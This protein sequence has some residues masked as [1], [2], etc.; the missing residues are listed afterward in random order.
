MFILEYIDPYIMTVHWNLWGSKYSCRY[1]LVL[2]RGV[3]PF[4]SYFSTCQITVTSRPI[5]R[6]LTIY[7]TARPRAKFANEN[8]MAL[9]DQVRDSWLSMAPSRSR[10]VNKNAKTF[11]FD[12]HFRFHFLIFGLVFICLCFCFLFRFCFFLFFKSNLKV[13]AHC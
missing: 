2:M 1:R 13:I 8:A 7:G 9:L 12:S 3:S 5:K 4:F 10:G 6:E 11:Y